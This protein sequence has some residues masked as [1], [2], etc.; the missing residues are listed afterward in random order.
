MLQSPAK[1]ARIKA[2]EP[3]LHGSNTSARKAVRQNA[4][5]KAVLSG[6]PEDLDNPYDLAGGN[7]YQ[8]NMLVARENAAAKTRPAILAVKLNAISSA[9]TTTRSAWLKIRARTP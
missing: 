9:N 3:K 2:T 6:W 1:A 7:A 5:I 4:I 8:N